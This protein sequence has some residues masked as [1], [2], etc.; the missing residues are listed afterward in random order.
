MLS[1][2]PHV[3]S[4]Q[5]RRSRYRVQSSRLHYTNRL[6]LMLTLLDHS[7]ML[8]FPHFCWI[9]IKDVC[10]VLRNY[11]LP[12]CLMIMNV[13]TWVEFIRDQALFHLAI[14]VIIKIVPLFKKLRRS[15]VFD[16]NEHSQN[17]NKQLGFGL[18][19]LNHCLQMT[20]HFPQP[21]HQYITGLQLQ[22]SP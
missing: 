22:R 17:V 15:Q 7:C 13:V 18:Y 10:L 16:P 8:T 1:L 11:I 2:L 14:T 4:G 19:A 20:N 9:P 21:V 3:S 6:C 5:Q 12:W